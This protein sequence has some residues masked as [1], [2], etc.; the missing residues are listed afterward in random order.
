MS[1]TT[2]PSCGKPYGLVR[3]CKAW[4]FPR[5][6]YYKQRSATEEPTKRP[7]PKGF[8][9]DEELLF[10]IRRIIAE[11]PFSGEGYRKVWAQLRFRGV[12]TSK[13]RTLRIMREN[14]LSALKRIGHAHG[15]KAHD[16]TIKTEHVD[17]MWG[18]DMTTTLTVEEGNASVFFAIDH[19]S[20]ECVGIHAAK[21]GTRFEA[22]EPIRQ[23]MRHAFGCFGKDIGVG[24]KLRHDHGS[25]YVSD[26]F[27]K[28]VAF[29]G[30]KSSPSFVREPQGNGIAERFV[31]ILKE[32]L[33]WIRRFNTV[34][35]LRKALLK[36][37]ETYNRQWIIGRHGYKTPS[38]VRERQIVLTECAA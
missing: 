6:T 16:G 13:E 35:E 14:N 8:H 11:S 12:R 18:T 21:L 36:F 38:Q 5:S 26:V 31:R 2:S 29:L 22:L 1:R 10:H 15:P 30:I 28:E 4:D 19:C 9:S 27:Q 33:L 25:Q 23:G 34:E 7:G 37:K 17:E 3:V 32:N 20:L 24:L